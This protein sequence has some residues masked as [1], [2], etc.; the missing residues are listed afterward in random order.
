MKYGMDATQ[1]EVTTTSYVLLNITLDY[2]I[3]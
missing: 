3:R 1:P 2:K